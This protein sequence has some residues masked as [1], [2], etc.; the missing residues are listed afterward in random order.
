M[1]ST[2]H[3]MDQARRRV[4]DASVLSASAPGYPFI[5]MRPPT[6]KFLLVLSCGL[7]AG[8]AARR[9]RNAADAAIRTVAAEGW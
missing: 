5:L 4:T 1:I 2:S 8:K 3:P 9:E 6:G 7:A